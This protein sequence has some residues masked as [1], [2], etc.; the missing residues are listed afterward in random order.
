MTERRI[1]AQ[2]AE[3]DVAIV[4]GGMV[5]ATLALLLGR[6]GLRVAVIETGS[7]T[8]QW[9]ADRVD[10]RVSALTEASRQLFDSL[11]VWERMTNRRATPYT[12]MAVWDGAG[13]GEVRF[14]AQDVMAPT[15]GHI[16]ENSVITDTLWE[17][18]QTIPTVT[19]MASDS[20]TL[21]SEVIL[22]S[23]HESVRSLTLRSGRNTSAR[24]VVAA[25]G[26]QSPLR[27]MMGIGVSSWDTNQ[28]AIV[29]VVD[30]TLSHERCARQVF[31]PTGPLAFLPIDGPDSATDRQC[32]VVWSADMA[33][34][35]RLMALDDMT[36]ADE[37]AEAFEHRLGDVS[38][39]LPRHAFP[40]VQRHAQRYVL[41]SFALIGDAAHGIH[42]LAGQGANLGFLDA[43]V[44]A[45]ELDQ[46]TRQ[47]APLGDVRVLARYERRRRTDNATMLKAMEGFCRGFGYQHLMLKWARNAGLRMVDSVM[48]L[49][50]FFI[51]QA[52][53]ERADLPDIMKR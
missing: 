44:L 4:G 7:M 36:F 25:D 48:P 46:A 20:V 43:A 42:P 18:L 5:G 15:L 30:H 37:M 26:A 33:E 39:Q 12:G 8:P 47:G 29:T 23:A 6:Q 19:C 17:A 31:L 24:V 3:H 49:K 28:S 35:E 10:S 9:H 53:G 52:L 13:N 22:P 2:I 51:R 27:R 21:V 14:D 40:L 45:E 38:L 11:G 41:A 32:S 16:I 50:R 34:A 1:D